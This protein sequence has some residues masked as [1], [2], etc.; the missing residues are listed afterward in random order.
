VAA[1]LMPVS[2]LEVFSRK[3]F[4]G[5]LTSNLNKK[6]N[7]SIVV[8]LLPIALAAENCLSMPSTLCLN[9]GNYT[10][11]PTHTEDKIAGWWTFDEIEATD[12]STYSN[13]MQNPPPAG[14]GHRGHG[15]SAYFDGQI[16]STIPHIEAYEDSDTTYSFWFNLLQDST[17][18]WRTIIHK[19]NTLQEMS[20]TVMLWPKERRL[21][22][23][24]STDYFW[25]E[26]VDSFS[27][28]GFRRWTHVAVTTS[29][30]LLQ[31]YVNGVSDKSDVM[32]APVKFNTGDIYVG[33]DPWHAGVKAFIDD[34]RI[35]KGS[36]PERDLI[37]L[38]FPAH[39]DFGTS[40]FAL[41][42][43]FCNFM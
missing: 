12:Y 34:F 15:Y 9:G 37:A 3:Y 36:L 24:V 39:A 21:H 4:L 13:E 17:G 18:T 29:G 43:S 35:Y 28:I 30:Q 33:K 23:R 1:F 10:I 6:T 19:G 14:P 25:N 5:F 22:V 11:G 7:M 41:G 40:V 31:L 16:Q 32:K 2:C 8:L 42:C 27:V 26:G 20:N 38:A